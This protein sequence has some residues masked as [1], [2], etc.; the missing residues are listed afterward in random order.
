MAKNELAMGCFGCLA[1]CLVGFCACGGSLAFIGRTV[2]RVPNQ[3]EPVAG[4][5]ASSPK[6]NVANP[7][8]ARSKSSNTSHPETIVPEIVYQVTIDQDRPPIK[9]VVYVQ[10]PHRITEADLTSIAL[11]IKRQAGGRYQRIFIMYFLPG[12]N[13]KEGAW[14]TTHFNPDLAI[15]IL[16]STIE[17]EAALLRL[18]TSGAE[19]KD[20]I[21]QWKDSDTP[22]LG[23][24]IRIYRDGGRFF[25]EKYYADGVGEP[26]ELIAFSD[27]G[28]VRFVDVDE[29]GTYLR[30]LNDAEYWELRPNGRL[31]VCGIET[32]PAFDYPAISLTGTV[33]NDQATYLQNLPTIADVQKQYPLKALE[34]VLTESARTKLESLCDESESMIKDLAM[35]R[36]TFSQN[37]D[38]QASLEAQGTFAREFRMRIDN[39]KN[40]IASFEPK[41]TRT[42]DLSLHFA[43]VELVGAFD[44]LTLATNDAEYA[45][46][47]KRLQPKLRAIRAELSRHRPEGGEPSQFRTWTSADGSFRTEAKFISLL[48]GKVR[49]QKANGVRIEVELV[50]L[51]EADQQ[52][53]QARLRDVK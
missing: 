50:Q 32:G 29:L 23:T 20:Y 37:P 24:L 27:S 5:T 36:A 48:N 33:H 12:M 15:N 6:S 3:N 7:Q 4:Q 43:L 49:L 16:G 42:I 45:K 10:L 25:M 41:G 17:T 31:A 26:N 2:P 28:Q 19:T 9:Q 13:T 22:S 44:W 40:E 11:K 34:P 21:G 30:Q 46:T 38:S 47:M 51:S 14:A 18:S 1:V 35:A 52:L 39:A 8:S 53:L